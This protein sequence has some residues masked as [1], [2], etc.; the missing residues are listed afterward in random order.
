MGNHNLPLLSR[1]D[2]AR[3]GRSGWELK[4]LI[5][6]LESAFRTF[7]SLPVEVSH[8]K[9]LPQSDPETTIYILIFQNV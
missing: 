2:E 8:I 7:I 1:P 3:I 5:A 4:Q 6:P 9:I